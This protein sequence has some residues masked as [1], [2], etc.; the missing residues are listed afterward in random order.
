MT[1]FVGV[2]K[3]SRKVLFKFK[4]KCFCKSDGKEIDEDLKYKL[5]TT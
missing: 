1:Y 2:I 5:R 3:I 4:K